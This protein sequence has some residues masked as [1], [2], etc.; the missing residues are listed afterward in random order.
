MLRINQYGLEAGFE[1]PVWDLQEY[2][3]DNYK[4]T[5]EGITQDLTQLPRHYICEN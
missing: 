4:T 2:P 1:S 5:Y 3:R